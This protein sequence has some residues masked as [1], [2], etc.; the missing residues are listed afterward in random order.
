MADT[1]YKKERMQFYKDRKRE[2][3]IEKREVGHD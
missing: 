2:S 1:G 3:K